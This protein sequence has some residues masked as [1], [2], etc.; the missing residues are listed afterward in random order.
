MTLRHRARR[1][2]S[3]RRFAALSVA[4]LS[5]GPIGVPASF[6]ADGDRFSLDGF[7]TLGFV[8]SSEHEADFTGGLLQ[9][10]GAGHSSDWSAEVD[11]RLGLQLSAQ[12]SPRVS[13][14]V[15]VISEQRYDGSF[16]PQVEWANLKFEIAPD[17]DLRVG[18]TVLASFL[19]S[20]HRKV[21]FANP[22]VRPPVEIYGLVPVS[23]SDG[24][25]MLYRKQVG[26]FTHTLQAHYGHSHVALT[27]GTDADADHAIGFVDT[28]E[29]GAATL[30]V[31]LQQTDLTLESFNTLFDAFRQ[32]GP[33][34]IALADRFDADPTQFRFFGL[35]GSY[36]PGDWFVMGEWGRVQSD[37]A[38]GRTSAWYGTA[39]Y[40]WNQLTPYVTL[41]RS[42][43]DS[44]S[45]DPGLNASLYPPE[46]AAAIAALNAG[47][48][49]ILASSV[50]QQTVSLGA[51]WD[52]GN[53][54]ALKLQYDRIDLGAGSAGG[55]SNVQPGF[56]PGGDLDL[57]S[58][59][60]DF[61]F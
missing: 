4:V 28:I 48:N 31:S 26:R 15:Q 51:R 18:R 37:S 45:S 24:V 1:A 52:F 44:A 53:R 20:D 23:N 49:S 12:F 46:Q 5:A 25:D 40:R 27:D 2:T 17:F 30:R 13:A 10:E 39:G 57:L 55:L 29:F 58:V 41:A 47:L 61:V 56:V 22:W 43:P 38:I 59:S 16:K 6:A 3:H 60:L 32:F 19:A 14:V 34:G 42:R 9:A 21:G 8:H 11:S 36:D 7:G 50:S 54:A 33:E 35:A